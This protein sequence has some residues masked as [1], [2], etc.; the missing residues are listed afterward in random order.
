MWYNGKYTSRIVDACSNPIGEVLSMSPKTMARAV[1]CSRRRNAV[2]S[3]RDREPA[4]LLLAPL[5]ALAD[6]R[7]LEIVHLL[8]TRGEMCV[9]ELMAAFGVS[10]SNVSFHLRSLKH[11]GL[12]N[13]RK[14][15]KW[16]YYSLNRAAF[17][18]FSEA[19]RQAFDLSKWPEKPRGPLCDD[20]IG[21]A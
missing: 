20:V 5:K 18:D 1:K 7:R 10:Q 9:C 4:R 21:G 13:S 15:G 11:A 12:V 19:C 14:A 6:A 3:A 17:N 16:M 8:M 2:L